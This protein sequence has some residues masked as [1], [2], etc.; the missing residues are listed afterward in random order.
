MLLRLLLSDPCC[1]PLG[2]VRGLARGIKGVAKL[3]LVFL[4]STLTAQIPASDTLREPIDVRFLFHYYEQDGDHSAVTGGMGGEKLED[5][6]ARIVINVPM[7]STAKL[8]VNGGWNFY[9]SASTDRISSIS[10]ASSKDHRVETEVIYINTPTKTRSKG[11]LLSGSSETDYMSSSVGLLW[12]RQSKDLVH[13]VDLIAR[14]WFDKWMVVLPDELRSTGWKDFPTD[15]RRSALIGLTY[16]RELSPRTLFSATLDPQLQ[17]GLLS[18][19]FHRVIRADSVVTTE[20]LPATRL[21]LPLSLRINHNVKG[22]LVTRLFI[23]L[24]T[25]NF[26]IKSFTASVDP[27]IGLTRFMKFTPAYRFYSQTG[28]KYFFPFMEAEVTQPFRTSDYDLSEFSSQ[29]LSALLSLEPLRGVVRLSKNLWLGAVTA[30]YY[31]L[32]R[33]DGLQAWWVSTELKWLVW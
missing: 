24:Y 29:R 20:V 21:R 10:S 30:G 19:P 18:T 16:K 1:F 17:W 11:F 4:A 9:T 5:R 6:S 26:G 3:S 22:R 28:S 14:A 23:R 31:R 13:G 32:W 2:L 25:D 15:K 27:V 8:K 7:D 12:G 33:S